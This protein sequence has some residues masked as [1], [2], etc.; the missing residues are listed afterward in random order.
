MQMPEVPPASIAMLQRVI[1]DS[2]DIWAT[3]G[4]PNSM[5]RSVAPFTPRCPITRRMASLAKT[6]LGRVPFRLT[7]MVFGSRKAQTPFRIPT[8]RSV[9]PTPAAKA[10]KAPWVQVWESPIITV[11]PGR[12][13]PFSGKSAWQTPFAPISKKSLMSW[14]LAQS[15]SIFAWVAVLESLLGVTWSITA[16]I[17]EGSKTLSLPR[18]MRSAMAIGVVISWHITTS[19]LSTLVPAK[20][21]S[22]RWAA[23]IF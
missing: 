20:G 5:T 16:L 8:S 12:M 21:S 11:F 9:V 23:N 7:R 19:M 13:K 10:P 3:M 2:I 18:A 6:P 17:F 1:L 14:R 4:P 15:R 22:T